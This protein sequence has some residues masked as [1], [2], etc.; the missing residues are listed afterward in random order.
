M[1][2]Q[3]PIFVIRLRPEPGCADA[4]RALRGVLKFLLRRWGLRAISVSIEKE[5]K[6]N[7]EVS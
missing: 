5:E 7:A 3:R 6:A 4:V 1:T 2:E